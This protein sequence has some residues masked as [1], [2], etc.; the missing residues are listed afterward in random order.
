VLHNVCGTVDHCFITTHNIHKEGDYITNLLLCDIPLNKAPC[1]GPRHIWRT[2]P[3]LW[4]REHR[5]QQSWVDDFAGHCLL[6]QLSVGKHFF[7][8]SLVSA[9]RISLTVSSSLTFFSGNR[10]R[11]LQRS[12]L[13]TLLCMIWHSCNNP[14]PLKYEH[15]LQ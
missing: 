9:I 11:H 3:F 7:I 8:P 13:F 14:M 2:V 10:N 1:T 6:L 12:A 5:W 4:P 15:L